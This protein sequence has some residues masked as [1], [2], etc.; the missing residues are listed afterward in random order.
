V[1]GAARRSTGRPRLSF[2]GGDRRPD[3]VSDLELLAGFSSLRRG[4]RSCRDLRTRPWKSTPPSEHIPLRAALRRRYRRLLQTELTD[5]ERRYVEK[6]LN[7][8]KSAMESLTSL[9][10]QF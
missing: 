7:E 8:E 3:D 2:S 4:P 5:L 6:R 1:N 9:P 10:Q